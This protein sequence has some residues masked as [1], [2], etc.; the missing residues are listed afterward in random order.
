M[1]LADGVDRPVLDHL[2]EGFQVISYDWRYVYV[3]PA[4]AKQGR[5]TPEALEGRLMWEAYPGIELSPLFTL[6]KQAMEQRTSASLENHFTHADGSQRWFELR[7]EPV[8]QG[9]C[10]HS[11]DI[12]D[13][14]RAEASLRALTDA[15]ELRVAQRTA[16]LEKS[17]RALEVFCFSVSH[18]L[19][20][21]LRAVDGFS[22]LLAESNAHRLDDDGR[23]YLRRVQ[24][25]AARMGRLIEELLRLARLA[26]VEVTRK[27]VDLTV[28]C[29]ALA[30]ELQQGEPTRRVEWVIAPDLR[31]LCDP[32]LARIALENLL[33]NAF[34]FTSKR[35]DARIEVG[36]SA[37]G[38][39]VSDN[40]VGFDMQFA[41]TLFRPFGRLH[42]EREFPGTGIG[43]ATV[44]RI[45]D[46]HDGFVRAH[47]EVGHGARLTLSFGAPSDSAESTF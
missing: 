29:R 44:H 15:L 39:V 31:A 11:I 13:R 5:S 35:T 37:A 17:N 42:S 26:T 20:T 3:N 32:A 2:L 1:T 38:L 21:P 18:D 22:A 30:D 36:P 16:E 19:R 40:G 47:G 46:K 12:E 41:G 8:P 14:K 10:V 23:E 6:M 34:K 45:A 27:H 43:L 7:I 24:G 25:A 4:A 9:L 28:L 33:Q